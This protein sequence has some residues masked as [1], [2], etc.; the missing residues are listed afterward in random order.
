MPTIVEQVLRAA[1]PGRLFLS[2]GEALRLVPGA[3]PQNPDLAGYQRYLRGT[4]PWPTRLIA[5]RRVVAVADIVAAAAGDEAAPHA[6]D[7]HGRGGRPRKVA[8]A[9][10]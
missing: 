1:F 2:L 8:R 4:Y 5:H 7:A 3:T 6:H 9:A 10:Q